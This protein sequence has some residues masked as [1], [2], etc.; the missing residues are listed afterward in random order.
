LCHPG[1]AK[2]VEAIEEA[3]TL[4]AGSLTHEREVLR[5][6][7][8]M[9]APTALFVLDR[10]LRDQPAGQMML[11]ALGPGFTASTLPILF[12]G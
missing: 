1:G 9:S 7:G 10:V 12:E 2:V 3:M 4:D 8:N 5:E 6:F 11:A